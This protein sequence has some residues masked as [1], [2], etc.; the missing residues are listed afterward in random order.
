MKKVMS[1][2][3]ALAMLFSL[4]ACAGDTKSNETE[5]TKTPQST[6]NTDVETVKVIDFV[7]LSGS[8][9][10][11]GEMT[12]RAIDLMTEMINEQGGIKSLGGAKLEIVYGD[13]QSDQN[14]VK[15]V[16]ERV[17]SDNPD[18][19]A[20]LGTGGS[21]YTVT[22]LPIYEKYGIPVL[23]MN[24]AESIVSSG[25]N[26]I[27]Q[28][29]ACADQTGPMQV[30]FLKYMNEEYGYDTSKCAILYTDNDYGLS[31][32][33]GSE[34]LISSTEGLELVYS[35]AFPA[36]LSDATSIITAIKAS[37]AEALFLTCDIATGTVIMDAMS[38]LDYHPVVI[39]G[40]GA[41]VQNSFAEAL[42]DSCIGLL[43]SSIA[44]SNVKNV[45]NDE[46]FSEFVRRYEELYGPGN[47]YTC[48]VTSGLYIIYQ[49]L[50]MCGSTD[51]DVLLETIKSEEFKS[52]YPQVDAG[53][54]SFDENGKSENGV[55]I[56]VQW[57]K[58]EDGKYYMNAIYPEDCVG[59]GSTF[60]DQ[61]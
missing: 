43:S 23:S 40:G 24:V 25:Y 28:A 12:A 36:D 59:D 26:Y 31:N 58:G 52:M 18:A 4:A 60:L 49:A 46:F 39:G 55:M 21:A 38:A 27:I 56:M 11:G 13:I 15:T 51:R 48:A 17:L 53:L 45:T 30:E 41:M 20:A 6:E 50:E 47:E 61:R 29:A 14:Q 5:N 9:S 54:S 10:V 35:E 42:G 33:Q 3:L 8:A 44:A 2:V 57:Q 7:N 22:A 37:G 34:A 32:A 1:V 19:V 16:I